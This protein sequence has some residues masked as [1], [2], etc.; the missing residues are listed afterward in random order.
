[1]NKPAVPKP[2][3]AGFLGSI[4]SPTLEPANNMSST[5][6]ADMTFRMDPKW[7]ARFKATAALHGL[8]MKE[9]L[10]ESFAAWEEKNKTRS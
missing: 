10:V 2:V 9:L 5:K 8:N 1:M 7:H 6:T 4:D 3:R